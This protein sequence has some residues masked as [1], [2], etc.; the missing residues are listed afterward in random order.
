M[1]HDI[2][3]EIQTSNELIQQYRKALQESDV[4]WRNDEIRRTLLVHGIE[5]HLE[6]IKRLK[7]NLAEQEQKKFK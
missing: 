7:D 1:T 3:A 2:I 5:Y 4:P 6:R